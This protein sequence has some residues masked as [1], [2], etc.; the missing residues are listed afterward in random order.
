M[1]LRSTPAEVRNRTKRS[2]ERERKL[3]TPLKEA[4]TNIGIDELGS[5]D[6]I[7]LAES[8]DE[9]EQVMNLEEKKITWADAKQAMTRSNR[10]ISD[11]DE[12]D[13]PRKEIKGL[14]LYNAEHGDVQK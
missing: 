10:I 8:D 3:S 7:W 12:V 13:L 11:G 14:T 4:I 2:R 1:I 5:G 6:E 9:D